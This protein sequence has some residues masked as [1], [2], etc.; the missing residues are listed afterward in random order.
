MVNVETRVTDSCQG[1]LDKSFFTDVAFG[2]IGV[3]IGIIISA[4]ANMFK[5]EGING[6]YRRCVN[7]MYSIREDNALYIDYE[8]DGSNCTNRESINISNEKENSYLK[9]QI[10][11]TLPN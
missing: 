9:F 11:T 7:I 10:L 8:Y 4:V 3:G 2:L 1:E 5:I 6:E